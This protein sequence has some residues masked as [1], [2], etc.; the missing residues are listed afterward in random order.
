MALSLRR[1]RK[2]LFASGLLEPAELRAFERSLPR[3]QRP[4]SAD[5]LSRALVEAEKLTGFQAAEI[6]AGRGSALV[7]G[8]YVVLDRIGAGGMGQVFKA[9]HRRMQRL[10]ALKTLPDQRGASE[11]SIARFRREILSAARLSHPNIVAAYD[12][13]VAQQIHFLVMEYVDGENL[14]EVVR[15]QG[16]IPI[17]LAVRY[18]LD[19]A[20]GLAYAHQRGL[21]HRDVKPSNL[22]VGSSGT[23]KLLDLGLARTATR[24]AGAELTMPGDVVGTLEYMAPEQASGS[25]DVDRRA[26][27]YGLGCTLYRLV[28]CEFPY[29]GTSASALIAA[30]R[31]EKIP[32]LRA[33]RG[34]I[35]RAL[36]SLFKR[37][38]AKQPAD[39][40][41]TMDEVV[42]ALEK[43]RLAE[44]RAADAVP[45]FVAEVSPSG[46]DLVL[47]SGAGCA[48]DF[49][50]VD[51]LQP[52][53]GGAADGAGSL[54]PT[55]PQVGRSDH[56][57]P[58]V[59][60][61]L[62]LVALVAALVGISALSW[63]D[64]KPEL[65]GALPPQG[66]ESAPASEMARRWSESLGVP[67][68]MTNSLGMRFVLIP[69][70]SYSDGASTAA[71]STDPVQTPFYC[72]AHELTVAQFRQFVAAAGYRA[73][74]Q[75]ESRFP[76][77]LAQGDRHPVVSLTAAD[78]EAFCHWLS[79]VEGATY[80][81]P[82][83][84]EWAHL[85]GAG[86]AG[87][88]W[89]GDGPTTLDRYAW[90]QANAGGRTHQVGLLEANPFGI[91]DLLGN[92]AEWS[93]R[94]NFPSRA[95]VQSPPAAQY[96]LCGGCWSSSA[97][98]V[99]SVEA[100]D[101]TG[102]TTGG[103]RLVLELPLEAR[104]PHR[105]AASARRS[106]R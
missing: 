18:V 42:R 90:Y 49:Q 68:S 85:C 94:G 33:S 95:D 22:I 41:Q 25:Q 88:R 46:D 104:W 17:T 32:S 75:G 15:Q 105:S 86:A 34:D 59:S 60:P 8:N 14:A 81:L 4:A 28:T 78:A 79:R 65:S 98:A 70:A 43:L 99:G 12:A 63:L 71:A 57:A 2:L 61:L 55:S 73:A 67:V 89:F 21:V 44:K 74:R 76:G 87:R 83:E 48:I 10:V 93:V 38:V 5:E 11:D 106:A 31:E 39:R 97:T 52:A 24:I 84:A 50:P 6:L 69:P 19:A 58:H 66:G 9:W 47:V 103:L 26:D 62:A 80:R 29:R 35:P 45:D 100:D 30:H 23:V 64:S 27:V 20:R 36:D 37:M 72:G 102:T 7:L 54:L 16:A 1:Y 96:V 13:D 91:H 77:G 92:A 40:F 82:T 51:D 3:A 53:E 101:A 56:V